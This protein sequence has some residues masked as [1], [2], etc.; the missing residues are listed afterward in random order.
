MVAIPD[1]TTDTGPHISMSAARPIG[2][3]APVAASGPV[4][5]ECQ[6][7]SWRGILQRAMVLPHGSTVSRGHTAQRR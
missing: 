4:S 7:P 3:S 5:A 1:R 2:N 6:T